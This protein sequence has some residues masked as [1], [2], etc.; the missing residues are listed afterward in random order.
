MRH[1]IGLAGCQKGSGP[2][3]LESGDLISVRIVDCED[4]HIALRIGIN[5]DAARLTVDEAEHISRLLAEAAV[6]ARSRRPKQEV[7]ETQ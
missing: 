2:A 7:E 5:P 4:N 3:E 1:I 6:R